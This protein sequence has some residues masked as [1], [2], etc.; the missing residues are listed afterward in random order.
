MGQNEGLSNAGKK[1]Q[2]QYDQLI[3][4]AVKEDRYEADGRPKEVEAR[5]VPKQHSPKKGGG[6]K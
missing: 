4:K 5:T 6:G 3:D 1:E 2:R